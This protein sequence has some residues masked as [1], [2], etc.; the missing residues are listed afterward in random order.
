[1][2]AWGLQLLEELDAS[3][4]EQSPRQE[5]PA[6]TASPEG[7]PVPP[8]EVLRHEASPKPVCDH[9]RLP[10]PPPADVVHQ[11]HHAHARAIR[12][13]YP[14]LTSE[15]K[16]VPPSQLLDPDDLDVLEK[17]EQLDDLVYDAIAGKDD[18][19][20]QLQS[21]WPQIRDELGPELLDESQEQYLRYALSIWE[22]SVR[23]GTVDNPCRVLQ[24]L[25][26]LCLLFDDR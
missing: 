8:A 2:P 16:V 26:V 17:L 11:A 9:R 5:A 19:I 21:F 18:A 12:A 13:L 3:S 1:L 6:A 22:E 14:S 4:L 20:E 25:D 7:M 24:A 23:E 15:S 10:E